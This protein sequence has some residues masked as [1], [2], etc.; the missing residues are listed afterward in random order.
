MINN[1]LGKQK[2]NVPPRNGTSPRKGASKRLQMQWKGMSTQQKN[3]NRMMHIDSDKDGV[4]NKWDCQPRNRMKQDDERYFIVVTKNNFKTIDEFTDN[5]L[6]N[7]GVVDLIIGNIF[8]LSY[9]MDSEAAF[10][11]QNKNKIMNEKEAQIFA[12]KKGIGFILQLGYPP[13]VYIENKPFEF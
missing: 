13:R 11:K 1:I 12:R 2:P 8:E 4:P 10:I 6:S 5:D 7:Y 3:Q 9:D